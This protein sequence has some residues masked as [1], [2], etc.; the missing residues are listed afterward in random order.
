M[1]VR[2]T[3]SDTF[4][5][6][7]G[8]LNVRSR[9]MRGHRTLSFQTR[10]CQRH[11]VLFICYTLGVSLFGFDHYRRPAIVSCPWQGEKCH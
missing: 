10:E 2:G 8:G 11:G 3:N 6:E 5:P 9:V 7:F 1:G 4:S